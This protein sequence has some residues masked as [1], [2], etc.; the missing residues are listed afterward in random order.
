MLTSSLEDDLNNFIS[1]ISTTQ[2]NI[3]INLLE[4]KK[5]SSKS[6]IFELKLT[7]NLDDVKLNIP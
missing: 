4:L 1:S 7:L 2:A 5:I 6:T 3:I